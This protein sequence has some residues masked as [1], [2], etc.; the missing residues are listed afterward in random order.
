RQRIGRTAAADDLDS[1]GGRAV[2]E[3]VPTGQEGPQ[4]DIGDL[5]IG[6]HQ[7][8]ESLRGD[9]VDPAGL[10]D[11][12]REVGGLTGQQAEFTE[13]PA[14]AVY[15]YHGFGF[16]AG[17]RADDLDRPG[18]DHDQVIGRVAGP[19]HDVPASDLL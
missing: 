4:Q 3:Q 16:I 19:E 2:P 10:H 8:P 15:R 11:T 17:G 1:A 13:E 6:V 7:A 9:A 12:G 14:G 5:R 18:L